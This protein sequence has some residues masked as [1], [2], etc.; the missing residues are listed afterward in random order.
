MKCSYGTAWP[1]N[2][3]GE[4]SLSSYTALLCSLVYSGLLPST[5]HRSALLCHLS[6]SAT[7]CSLVTQLQSQTE[8]NTVFPH[9]WKGKVH[10]WSQKGTDLPAYIHRNPCPWFL[11]CLSLWKWGLQI[12]RVWLVEK[13]LSWMVRMELL[14]SFF[15]FFFLLNIMGVAMVKK[16]YRSQV[17]NSITYGLYTALSVYHQ[18]SSICK[19]PFNSS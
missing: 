18:K 1:G 16:L 9:W 14:W 5:L 2:G 4:R 12:L 6:K 11:T 3:P 8:G 17:H 10:S 13:A 15:F 7:L 19:S